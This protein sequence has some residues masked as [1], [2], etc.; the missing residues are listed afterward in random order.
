MTTVATPTDPTWSEE[1]ATLSLVTRDDP[2]GT[3]YATEPYLSDG[4]VGEPDPGSTLTWNANPNQDFGGSAGAMNP[5]TVGPVTDSAG[6]PATGDSALTI[7][8]RTYTAAQRAAVGAYNGSTPGNRWGG[9][10]ISNHK[11]RTF[12]YGYFEF[13]ACFPT[14]GHGMWPALWFFAAFDGNGSDRGAAEID[15]LEIFGPASGTPWYSSLHELASGGSPAPGFIGSVNGFYVGH[16]DTSRW[17][18]YG[19]DWQEDALTFYVDRKRVA[20]KRGV[21]A[22]FY[23]GVKMAIRMDYTMTKDGAGPGSGPEDASTPDPLMMC[24]DYIRM[25]PS[26]AAARLPGRTPQRR[27]IPFLRRGR[28]SE[29]TPALTTRHSRRQPTVPGAVSGGRRNRADE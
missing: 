28:S 2:L 1:F 24:V 25:W 10:L 20:R 4:M 11:V 23:Q 19:L 17:H 21:D 26:F 27:P 5:F 14:A 22:R 7:L 3:W 12:T 13:R 29:P 16:D 8:C 9:T 6:S 15:L 18:A